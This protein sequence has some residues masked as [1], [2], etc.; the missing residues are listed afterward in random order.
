MN[1]KAKSL[2]RNIRYTVSAN[3]LVLAISILLN[4]FVPKFLGV[5]D[6][7]YWQ[8]YVFYSGY[9]GFFHFGWLDGIYLKMGGEDYDNLDK[10]SIGNQFILFFL[11][12]L[13]FSSLLIIYILIN[14]IEET[15]N[16]ILLFIALSLIITN[17]KT[18]VIYILQTTNRIK[19]YAILSRSDRYIYLLIS[20]AY[21]IF[22][23]NNFYMLIIMDLVS[24]LIMLAWGIMR[25][26]DLF[27]YRFRLYKKTFFEAI[28][29]IKVGCNLMLSNIASLLIMGISRI[30]I[31]RQWSITT[32]GK[33]S[34]A[35]SISNMFMTFINAVGIVMFP[36]L[37]RTPEKLLPQLYLK[38]RHTFVPM[39]YFLLIFYA[40]IAFILRLWL[41][42]YS[43]SIYFMGFLFPMVIYEGR[44][45]LLVSTYL[46]T[47]RREKI[48]LLSNVITLI[49]STIISY[50]ST[51]IISNLEVAILAIIISITFRCLITEYQLL[52]ILNIK[53][54]KDFY[55]E[56]LLAGLFIYFSTQLSL[57]KG[58]IAYV[59]VFGL[60]MFIQKNNFYYS[61]I[62][63]IKLTKK[64]GNVVDL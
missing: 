64:E 4:L 28:D 11:F 43:D 57:L 32:F 21:L 14:R 15:K 54:E 62:S 8:L 38:L 10:K 40:P 25:V 22:I 46:K 39:T 45:A 1:D 18:F 7:S 31:E 63:L 49:F 50:I 47:I 52:R 42:N 20:M 56:I 3:F 36:M 23:G 16:I 24:K 55:L 48:I 35:L 12:Q 26:S 6:Y 5:T 27:N 2:I 34:F 37:R 17:C 53:L 13:V 41:P 58:W 61:F 19:E 60:Y 9:I 29:N 33:L 30:F 44:M 51:F 59:F